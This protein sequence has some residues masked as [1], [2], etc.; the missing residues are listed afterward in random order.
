MLAQ[1]AATAETG[2]TR[3]QG[4]DFWTAAM[5]LPCMHLHID[6]PRNNPTYQVVPRHL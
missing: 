5:Q 4:G 1:S 6:C 3:L 2:S